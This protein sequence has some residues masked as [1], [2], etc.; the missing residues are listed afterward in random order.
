MLDNRDRPQK[1]I[2][3]SES[4]PRTVRADTMWIKTGM[5]VQ[6]EILG[7]MSREKH[8]YGNCFLVVRLRDDRV[9]LQECFRTDQ[10]ACH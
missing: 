1:S 3:E 5:S 4:S 10:I 8:A 9:R 6:L 2:T 7:G